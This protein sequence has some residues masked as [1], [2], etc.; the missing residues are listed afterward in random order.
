MN[1][2]KKILILGL[3]FLSYNLFSQTTQID[4]LIFSNITIV[5]NNYKLPK[6]RAKVVE[7]S[8]IEYS[9]S[10]NKYYLL[11][12]SA[13]HPVYYEAIILDNEKNLTVNFEKEIKINAKAFD[14]ESIRRNPRTEQIFLSEEYD[15]KSMIYKVDKNNNLQ[16]IITLAKQPY[17]SGFEGM[18]FNAEGNLLWLSQERA[19][20]GNVTTIFCYDI[21]NLNNFK[22]Y[23]YELDKLP[24]DTENDNGISEILCL[25]NDTLIVVERAYLALENKNSIRIYQASVNL[26]DKTDTNL[27]KS[28]LLTNFSAVTKIDNIEG[29]CLSASQQ[30]LIFVSD[31]N[32]SKNQKTQIVSMK[33]IYMK[34]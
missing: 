21:N 23:T 8:G 11:P 6:S 13:K 22:T 10:D 4:T 14:G 28:K 1:L 27:H 26:K 16:K 32:D 31:N 25:S 2:T 30:E 17:N 20:V 9:G 24:N 5:A 29:V 19:D 12:Q 34:P 7:L 3:I 18:S 33:I 15:Y